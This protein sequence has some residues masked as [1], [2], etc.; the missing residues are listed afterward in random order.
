MHV[1]LEQAPEASRGQSVDEKSKHDRVCSAGSGVARRGRRNARNRH[2]TATLGFAIAWLDPGKDIGAVVR[3]SVTIFF[4][5]RTLPFEPTV[6]WIFA[7]DIEATYQELQSSGANIVE[8]LELKPWGIRQFT[9]R[10]GAGT[11]FMSTMADQARRDKRLKRR[12]TKALTLRR[13]PAIQLR[14]ERLLADRMAPTTG[15]P[16]M[17][18]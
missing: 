12:Q 2:D 4:R 5:K 1:A 15:L 7:Q 8:P 17:F 11:S 18:V 9:V 14:H 3:G 10:N 13:E 16:G 6:H